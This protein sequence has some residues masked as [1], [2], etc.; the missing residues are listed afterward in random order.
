V[1]LILDLLQLLKL[2]GSLLN[3]LSLLTDTEALQVLISY[4]QFLINVIY[5]PTRRSQVYLGDLMIPIYLMFL[6]FSR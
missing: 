1:I 4:A 5:V 2:C 6:L 3:D